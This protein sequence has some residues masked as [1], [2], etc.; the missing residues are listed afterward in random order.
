[1]DVY[2]FITEHQ[3][4]YVNDVAEIADEDFDAVVEYYENR[5]GQDLKMTGA[6]PDTAS[7]DLPYACP[8]LDK[9]KGE[10]AE[11]AIRQFR[12]RNPGPVLVS[13]KLDGSSILLIYKNGDLSIRT[14][15]D[16]LR[17]KNVTF[18]KEYMEFPELKD[19]VVRG[20]L[21][22]SKTNFMRIQ[23]HIRSKGNKGLNSRNAV[24]G[25]V[26]GKS[27]P[28]P[29]I[30][31][32][33]VFVAFE[34]KSE[35]NTVVED[36]QELA[37]LGF[38]TPTFEIM[39][40]VTMDTLSPVLKRR[41]EESE[42]N[43]DGIVLVSVE[44]SGVPKTD[45]SNP[46]YAIA[47]KEDVHTATVIR[48]L[49]WEITSR[50]GKLTPRVWFDPVMIN[51]TAFE[52][53]TAHNA[54]F[55]A[56]HGLTVGSLITVTLGG[57][58]IP[59]V[60]SNLVPVDGY[61]IE[62]ELPYHV[63]E[64][65]I[66]FYLDDPEIPEVY[67]AQI[68]NF[69]KELGI[70][71]VGKQ[72]I[73][74][75]YDYGVRSIESFIRIRV[76]DL[77]ELERVGEPGASKIFNELHSALE[78][79]TLSRIMAASFMFERGIGHGTMDLFLNAFPNWEFEDVSPTDLMSVDGIGPTRSQQIYE[80]LQYFRVWIRENPMCRPRPKN[81]VE[82][83]RDLIGVTVAVSGHRDTI[84]I[85]YLRERGATVKE[86]FVKGINVVLA[87]DPMKCRQHKK[88]KESVGAIIVPLVD[89]ERISLYM[90]GELVA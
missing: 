41:R 38:R 35:S 27:N 73:Q 6:K 37:H 74:K 28:D 1:M 29:I 83:V 90:S 78:R 63:N 75:L 81:R 87:K 52:K 31:R 25:V 72:T 59:K 15:G 49:T 71:H 14:T 84:A 5:T 54:A 33:C 58:I 80:G 56:E 36:Y 43:I 34:F 11:R 17:G 47:Y 88:F 40:S 57:S 45:T 50:Y 76:D 60:V 12:E 32:E 86:S 24:N 85:D 22:I 7:Y 9:A 55:V 64:S 77:M 3:K 51:G 16:G 69:V 13:D 53:A 44:N 8:S 65:E 39:D 18:L 26:N 61:I 46:E 21:V 79:A 66:D 10:T 20:E 48:D 62:P 4:N 67:M 23:E 42:F 68:Q 89:V 82:R 30:I 19:G 70:K 2:E